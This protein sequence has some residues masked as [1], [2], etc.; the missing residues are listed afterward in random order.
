MICVS[1]GISFLCVTLVYRI[2]LIF[3]GSLIS[4][5]WNRSRNLFN[6]NLSH[7]AVTPMGSMNSRNLFNEFLQS[8]SS[9]KFRPAKYKHYT[10]PHYVPNTFSYTCIISLDNGEI[11]NQ[12]VDEHVVLCCCTC[13]VALLTCVQTYDKGYCQCG[14]H[15]PR[16][17]LCQSILHHRLGSR[18]CCSKPPL[19]HQEQYLHQ[20][21]GRFHSLNVYLHH[22]KKLS[23]WETIIF[24]G[25]EIKSLCYLPHNETRPGDFH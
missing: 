10:V 8:S 15:T 3:R 7:C 1:V 16:Q 25:L 13:F 19:S 22:Y 21:G 20:F 12:S 17:R 6:E 11:S 5:I 14:C 18:H 2:A 23:F 4:R 24:H 9:R